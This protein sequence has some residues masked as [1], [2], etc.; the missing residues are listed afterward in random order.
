M[1]F[2]GRRAALAAG[3]ARWWCLCEFVVELFRDESGGLSAPVAAPS[4]RASR[5]PGVCRVLKKM[6]VAGAAVSLFAGAALA[7]ETPSARGQ[8]ADKKP[9][10][11]A[12]AE[13]NA[14]VL[15]QP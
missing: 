10:A 6:L 4:V 11:A 15:F 13:P 9:P 2:T 7:Q 14:G 8:N 1:R 3:R 5:I 12:T